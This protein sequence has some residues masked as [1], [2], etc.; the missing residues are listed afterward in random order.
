VEPWA[1]FLKIE[2]VIR[3]EQEEHDVVI[4]TQQLLNKNLLPDKHND[5]QALMILVPYGSCV[6]LKAS[7]TWM[8]LKHFACSTTV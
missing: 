5:Y 3:D 4:F 6:I 2:D 8:L 7:K 1:S